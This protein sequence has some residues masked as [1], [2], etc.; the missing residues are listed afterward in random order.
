MK[1]LIG[2][3]LLSFL[4]L[5]SLSSSARAYLLYTNGP[6]NGT[7]DG[8][9]IAFY[10]TTDSFTL[11]AN[12]DVTQAIFYAWVNGGQ[13][14]S[15]AWTVNAAIT[16]AALGGTTYSSITGDVISA[17]YLFT[18]GYGYDIYKDTIQFPSVP[19]LAGTYWL[20]LTDAYDNSGNQMFWDQNNG[21]SAAWG[22]YGYA[23]AGSQAFEIDGRNYTGAPE[24]CTLL[25]LGSGLAGLAAFRKKFRA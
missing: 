5:C 3:F 12:A 24:P 23:P 25:L 14:P 16:G 15:P 18:N 8:W 11:G 7:I 19:M 2:V 6:V 4:L 1:K 20:Q 21:P 9:S 17:D 10:T 13:L 22:S